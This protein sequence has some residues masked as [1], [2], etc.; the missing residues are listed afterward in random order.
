M[1]VS[2]FDSI[3]YTLW[4][5][6]NPY[7][8]KYFMK[9]LALPLFLGGCGL[10]TPPTPVQQSY[11]DVA[12]L[13]VGMEERKHRSEL[14]RFMGVDPVEYEWCAAFVNA[15]LAD[16]NIP[17]SETVSEYPLLAR[18]FM[19]WGEPVTDELEPGD[20]IVFA[21]GTEGWQGHV[22]FYIGTRYIDG[23][24]YY[25]IL[26]GNQNNKVSYELFSTDRVI[27]Q[28]RYS[29]PIINPSLQNILKQ[30]FQIH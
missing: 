27:A 30:L 6:V 14:N 22:G 7:K 23:V 3:I 28:R 17:G 11:L 13:Y 12:D 1:F 24:E 9:Y 10:I 15:V 25:L 18:G 4:K 20:I 26:G 8:K 29:P 2:L 16:Q 5:L 19:T 21:R